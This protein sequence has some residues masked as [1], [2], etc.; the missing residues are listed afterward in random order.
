M[1]LYLRGSRRITECLNGYLKS[2]LWHRKIYCIFNSFSGLSLVLLGIHLSGNPCKVLEDEDKMRTLLLNVLAFSAILAL[3]A[4]SVLAVSDPRQWHG[5]NI[6]RIRETTPQ[7]TTPAKSTTGS[8]HK[9]SSSKRSSAGVHYHKSYRRY[10]VKY[11]SSRSASERGPSAP[12]FPQRFSTIGAIRSIDRN[13]RTFR[14]LT[15]GGREYVVDASKADVLMEGNRSSFNNLNVG[16]SVRVRGSLDGNRITASTVNEV[17]AGYVGQETT[18]MGRLT[19]VR[20]DKRTLT[21]SRGGRNVI[22]HIPVSANVVM[23]G[24]NISY[25]TI[26]EGSSIKVKGRWTGSN[27]V[28]ASVVEVYPPRKD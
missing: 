10:K 20:L 1:L 21:M 25:E 17:T 4:T 22:I 24:Q 27:L 6:V 2:R 9:V 15:I 16:D 13:A 23:Y 14:V 8:D 11:A 7:K 19:G 28:E 3:Q 12:A 18:I 5:N 26:P